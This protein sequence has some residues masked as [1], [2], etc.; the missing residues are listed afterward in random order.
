LPVI[1]ANSSWTSAWHRYRD[2]TFDASPAFAPNAPQRP[3][4]S[5][6]IQ[7]RTVDFANINRCWF[8]FTADA[9]ESP[10]VISPELVRDPMDLDT[11][12]AS[13]KASRGSITKR[14]DYQRRPN[15]C[16]GEPRH[17]LSQLFRELQQCILHL[18]QSPTSSC[19]SHQDNHQRIKFW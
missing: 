8:K 18:L 16:L 10:L 7:S 3:D 14:T 11:I 2:Q 4:C 9:I 17:E 12:M 5:I 15:A 1:N 19:M 6:V 13:F